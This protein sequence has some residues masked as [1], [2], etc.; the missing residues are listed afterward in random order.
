[1]KWRAGRGEASQR[2]ALGL[3][4]IGAHRAGRE[5]AAQRVGRLEVEEVCFAAIFNSHCDIDVST[6][7]WPKLVLARTRSARTPMPTRRRRLSRGRQKKGV[8]CRL[9]DTHGHAT[10]H[11]DAVSCVALPCPGMQV[12]HGRRSVL[13]ATRGSCS[14]APWQHPLVARKGADTIWRLS[15]LTGW[16]FNRR[17]GHYKTP[18]QRPLIGR[19]ISMRPA[20]ACAHVI[21]HPD[22]LARVAFAIL[23]CSVVSHHA[24]FLLPRSL[25]APVA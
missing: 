3:V 5:A 17:R 23:L 16:K 9:H 25:L 10:R 8:A 19:L 4:V 20:Y 13:P 7:P 22:G 18:A 1:M 15:N 11:D 12:V 24:P 21:E 2:R 14:S 6:K